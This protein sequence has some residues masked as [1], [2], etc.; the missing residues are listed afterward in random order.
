MAALCLFMTPVK[1]AVVTL[2]FVTVLHGPFVKGQTISDK[3]LCADKDCETVISKA[4]ALASYQG[5]HPQLLSFKPN[6]IITIKS[7]SAGSN[8]RLWGGEV[9]GHRGYFDKIFVREFHILVTQ[10][11]LVVYTE[12]EE[13]VAQKTEAAEV[14]VAAEDQTNDR[15]KAGGDEKEEEKVDATEKEEEKVDATEKEEE[16]VDATEKEEGKVDATDQDEEEEEEEE[17]EDSEKEIFIGETWEELDTYDESEEKQ[18]DTAELNK[19]IKSKLSNEPKDD[20]NSEETSESVPGQPA[21]VDS[22]H[23]IGTENQQQPTGEDTVQSRDE[24]PTQPRPHGGIFGTAEQKPLK[25]ESVEEPEKPDQPGS[26]AQDEVKEEEPLKA[27]TDQESAGKTGERETQET[28][29]RDLSD[30]DIPMVD[31]K[32]EIPSMDIEIKKETDVPT[33]E[34]KE[35]PAQHSSESFIGNKEETETPRVSNEVNRSYG[36]EESK[37]QQRANSSEEKQLPEEAK[38]MAADKVKPPKEPMLASSKKEEIQKDPV[39]KK[40]SPK[41]TKPVSSEKKEPPKEPK[42]VSSEKKEPPKEPKPVSSEKKESPKETK[43]V[44]SEKKEPPKEAKPVSS[45]KKEPPK[46][47]K[48]VSSEKKEP[49]KESSPVSSIKEEKPKETIPVSSEKKE[50]SKEPTPTSSEK[51][52]LPKQPTPVTSQKEEPPKEPT[53]V[54][55]Q[56]EEPPKEPTPVS[57]E[58]EES[59]KEPTPDSIEKEEPPK[60]P[61]P[62]SSE[63]IE[64]PQKSTNLQYEQEENTFHQ[65][66]KGNLESSSPN[67]FEG[68]KPTE[69]SESAPPVKDKTLHVETESKGMGEG[70]E[71][72]N[73]QH[74]EASTEQGEA[75]P[76]SDVKPDTASDLKPSEAVDSGP[77]SASQETT[78]EADADGSAPEGTSTIPES[79]PELPPHSPPVPEAQKQT[80]S[81]VNEPSEVLDDKASKEEQAKSTATVGQDSS[82]KQA[83]DEETKTTET[84]SDQP[85]P[86]DGGLSGIL[87]GSDNHENEAPEKQEHVET[88]KLEMEEVSTET[89]NENPEVSQTQQLSEETDTA[90]DLVAGTKTIVEEGTTMVLDATGN[91]VTIIPP[92]EP[93]TPSTVSS[94]TQ[95][96]MPISFSES[97]ISQTPQL[98]PSMSQIDA[99]MMAT[100]NRET[101]TDSVSIEASTSDINNKAA[102]AEGAPEPKVTEDILATPQLDVSESQAE[103][104]TKEGEPISQSPAVMPTATDSAHTESTT[105]VAEASTSSIL[106]HSSVVDSLPSSYN[107]NNTASLDTIGST[108]HSASVDLKVER[109]LTPSQGAY[110]SADFNSR[111][112]LSVS[113]SQHQKPQQKPEETIGQLPGTEPETPQGEKQD[114]EF[115]QVEPSN[116]VENTAS[117]TGSAWA[118]SQDESKESQIPTSTESPSNPGEVPPPP[119]ARE[120]PDGAEP[121]P[122]GDYQSDPVHQTRKIN[123]EDLYHKEIEE[124]DKKYPGFAKT[125]ILSLEEQAKAVIEK[126]PPSMQSLLE[127]E[128]LGLSPTMTVLTSSAMLATLVLITL[129]TCCC[130]GGSKEKKQL[131]ASIG[132]IQE[133]E[134]KLLLATKER[135][136]IEDMVQDNKLES[137]HLKEEMTKYTKEAAKLQTELQ[138]VKLHNETLKNQVL[139]LQEEL[140]EVRNNANTSQ[141]EVKQQSKKTKD[142]EK[143]I[144][145]LDESKTRLEQESHKLVADL[146]SKDEEVA[147][148]SAQISGFAEQVGHLQTSKDQLLQEAED[149]KEKLAYSNERLEQ[150]DEEFKQ[151]QE[152][153]LFKENE[154]EVLKDCFLQ[155]KSFEDNGTN[156][157]DMEQLASAQRSMETSMADKMKAERQCQEA[158]TKLSVLSSYFKE[159][160]MQLQRELGEQEA[161]KKQNQSKLMSADETTQSMQQE[162]ELARAQSESLKRE[163]TSSE[164]DFRTQIAANEKKAHENWLAARAAER[165]LKESR[166]EAGVLRQKLA[167][168]ERRQ[169]IGPGGLIRPLPTRGMPPPGMINGPPPP[170]GMDRPPSRG[171]V[172]HMRDEEYLASPRSDRGSD[173]GPPPPPP[174]DPR[175][176]PGHLPPGMR[177]PP[178]PHGA[179]PPPDARSPPP[180]FD[181]A[182]SPPPRMPLPGMLDGRSPPPMPPFDRRPPP[183][184]MM[185]RRSPPFRLP[186]PDMLPPSHP[187]RGGPMPPP[188]LIGRGGSMSPPSGPESPRLDSRPDGR[189]PPYGRH[190]GPPSDRPSPRQNTQPSPRQQQSQV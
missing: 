109:D 177:P 32:S 107:S 76:E 27:P 75:I 57:S 82:E 12:Q 67:S 81:K 59:P 129:T 142:L 137:K 188:H 138:T 114:I 145:K 64:Q 147:N 159:K 33:I 42:P 21:P 20:S 110:E 93:H 172:P 181:D 79:K 98:Q 131:K 39:E 171:S 148:L 139:S 105:L 101:A 132:V 50:P 74:M 165:E 166:H 97:V 163:L 73:V 112:V 175:R 99:R 14:D 117:S 38:Q 19:Y 22:E 69:K 37:N 83:D 173:R 58:K 156:E 23:N 24:L 153:L 54:S 135:E 43:P 170:P 106:L 88:S 8:L 51:K 113:S 95:T 167:D 56:K 157:D 130:S 72:P 149:W 34:K 124:T 91:L 60:E 86:A 168:I 179:R 144:K 183:P 100:E 45:E 118:T 161:L 126:L 71:V 108:D 140:D 90:S 55:S 136:N 151:M 53:P 155:L 18:L 89:P 152:S 70:K 143:Q 84:M 10:P 102:S 154:L 164:R 31:P 61:T 178:P 47:A 30:E 103:M 15:A 134:S 41:E 146:K 26:E 115:A 174:F 96:D 35:E 3:R 85:A 185:D 92:N 13:P 48:R 189:Y 182:R 87:H 17:E 25:D 187:M 80:E 62:I 29:E 162:L 49:P 63:K 1:T 2:L 46:E 44:S 65:D 94:D 77:T 28:K 176:G 40:E 36:T 133:L 123:D 104:S 122:G 78:V 4:K 111:K 158:Q 186:P 52:E 141:G 121:V 9:N 160:E 180:H 190:P 150:R 116:V 66:I 5:N 169:F 125:V 7:K 127:Q 119:V 68:E 184:H 128:P 11:Q 6:D 16:K 120:D